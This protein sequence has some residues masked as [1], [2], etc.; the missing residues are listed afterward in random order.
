MKSNIQIISSDHSLV[1]E[2][3]MSLVELGYNIVDLRHPTELNLEAELIITDHPNI[4]TK[5][6]KDIPSINIHELANATKANIKDHIDKLLPHREPDAEGSPAS[7]SHKLDDRIFVRYK[8]KMIK[9]QID[10]ILYVEADR[11][12]CRIFCT[13]KD[14]IISVPLKNMETK[15]P[16]WAFFRIH[17]SY[18][19]NLNHI[20]E[21]AETHL[22]IARKALP[23]S[24]SLRPALLKRLQTI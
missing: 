2:I 19:V 24:K 22:V 10:Q 23:I 13:D 3:A 12:Y 17:R 9:L 20:D 16:D 14:Y 7:T 4:V 21:V 18:L 5:S 6:S 1:S 8:E 11:N 15:L